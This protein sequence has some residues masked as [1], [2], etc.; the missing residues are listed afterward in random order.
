MKPGG[1]L[2]TSSTVSPRRE[3]PRDFG[4]ASDDFRVEG[5]NIGS[6]PEIRA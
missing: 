2:L 6:A 3:N 4:P 5:M 1:F